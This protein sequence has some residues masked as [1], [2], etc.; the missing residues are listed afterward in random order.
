MNHCCYVLE[1]NRKRE[2]DNIEHKL[3]RDIYDRKR[4]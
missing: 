4:R 3:K 1:S 2:V